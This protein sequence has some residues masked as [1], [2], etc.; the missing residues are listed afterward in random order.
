VPD[1][2]Q[3]RPIAR[4]RVHLE[5]VSS[6]LVDPDLDVEF[7]REMVERLLRATQSAV[8]A[9]S[10]GLAAG[11][12]SDVEASLAHELADRGVLEMSDEWIHGIATRIRA[13]E[14]VRVPTVDE[15][16]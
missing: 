5:H 2:D 4:W 12:I 11:A 14:A 6:R 10:A 3:S 15:L 13:G 9:V 7:E 1:V 8:D 16:P